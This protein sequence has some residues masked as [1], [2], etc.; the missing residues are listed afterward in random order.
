VIE[1][2]SESA[3]SPASSGSQTRASSASGI[4]FQVFRISLWLG[5]LFFFI[6]GIPEFQ[7][8]WEEFGIELPYIT[9]VLLNLRYSGLT[10]VWPTLMMI[11]A[12]EIAARTIPNTNGRSWSKRWSWIFLFICIGF[13]AVAIALPTLTIMSGLSR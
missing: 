2:P 1:T 12:T 10:L 4:A 8:M 7:K 3:S 5:L 9:M 13:I 6:C 11:A